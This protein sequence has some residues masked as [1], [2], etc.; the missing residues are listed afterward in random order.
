[1]A[2][3]NTFS[4]FVDSLLF[5]RIFRCFR[6]AI[7][8]T[9]LVIGLMAL[10]ILCVLGVAMDVNKTVAVRGGDKLV[11]DR[12]GALP[13]ALTSPAQAPTEL[14]CYLVNP[15]NVDDYRDRYSEKA[16]V[17]HTMWNFGSARFTSAVLSLFE[18]RF[19]K[20]LVNIWYCLRAVGW[21]FRYHLVYSL[22]YFAA[23]LAVISVAGGGICRV[24]ALQFAKEEKPGLLESL[25]FGMKRFLSFFTAP[26]IPVG[27][28]AFFGIC[29]FV[30]GLLTNIPR[31]GEIIML[32]GMPLALLAGLLITL[33][34]IGLIAGAG[35]LYPAIG[36]EATD[37]FDAVSRAFSY[38]Y[39]RPWRTGFYAIIAAFYGGICY[40]FVRLCG[41]L[42]LFSTHRFLRLGVWANSSAGEQNKLT[43]IWPVPE[44]A[45]FAQL[46]GS[47]AAAGTEN[48]AAW[49]MYLFSLAVFGLVVSF[50]ISFYFSAS[51][52]IYALLRKHVDD[53]GLDE[54][55]TELEEAREEAEVEAEEPEKPQAQADWPQPEES[56]EETTQGDETSEQEPGAE[57]PADQQEDTNEQSP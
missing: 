56:G 17:F 20:V 27:I 45:N 39:A 54:V 25:K 19:G 14:H 18:L 38:I 40:L 37:G 15:E 16:G 34:L 1:M 42:L 43:T 9:K 32:V 26:L 31:L 48:F 35:F 52:V 4:Q 28:I 13:E 47:E 10:V 2:A 49:I 24:A 3:E 46:G 12:M 41:F 11:G 21:A 30:L 36:F 50:V 29:I 55:Y 23:T 53:I 57:P 51:T 6:I 7:Q 5:T 33:V 44:F 8:P 22:I